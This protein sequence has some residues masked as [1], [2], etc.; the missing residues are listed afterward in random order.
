M[1]KDKGILCTNNACNQRFTAGSILFSVFS[2]F[3]HFFVFLKKQI[4]LLPVPIIL[5]VSELCL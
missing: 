4:M 5:E 2:L 1:N 3:S